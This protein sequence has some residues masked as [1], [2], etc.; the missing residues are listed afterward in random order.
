MRSE[1]GISTMITNRPCLFP[2]SRIVAIPYLE[3]FVRVSLTVESNACAWWM[4]RFK[5]S[6]EATA[7]SRVNPVRVTCPI[8]EVDLTPASNNLEM[9]HV[10]KGAA[11]GY[12]GGMAIHTDKLQW[13][14]FQYSLAKLTVGKKCQ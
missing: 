1:I 5:N 4:K 6:F 8:F 11:H 7:S 12:V 13:I 3:L 2:A 10:N 9:R 14:N